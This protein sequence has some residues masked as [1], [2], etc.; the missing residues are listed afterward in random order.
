M[1]IPAKLSCCSDAV[2]AA[3]RSP[4]CCRPWST[5]IQRRLSMSPGITRIPMPMM[6]LRPWS[7]LQQGGWCCCTCRPTARGS[8]PLKCCGGTSVVKSPM[9]SFLSPSTR[10]S[11]QRT[12]SLQTTSKFPFCWWGINS[13]LSGRRQLDGPSGPHSAEDEALNASESRHENPRGYA[14][15]TRSASFPTDGNKIM[16]RFG[17]EC[18]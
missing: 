2:N 4:N 1:I 16:T 12:R 10:C 8:T 3:G 9:V 11:R 17:R 7:V 5:S 15:S 13:T 6:R 18:S 14:D